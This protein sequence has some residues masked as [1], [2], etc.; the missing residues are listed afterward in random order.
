V[1][2]AP[3]E[4]V[5]LSETGFERIYQGSAILLSWPLALRPGDT[6]EVGIR[7]SQADASR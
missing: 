7:L 3:V 1:S 4:T 2:W 6:W 5:S